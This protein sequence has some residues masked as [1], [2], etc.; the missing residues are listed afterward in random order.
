MRSIR[1]SIVAGKFVEFIY[2]F[3]DKMYPDKNFPKWAID[4]LKAV[5][6]DLLQRSQWYQLWKN[7]IIVPLKPIFI[8]LGNTLMVRMCPYEMT[9]IKVEAT[10]RFL[11]ICWWVYITN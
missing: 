3:M 10:S 5:Q 7:S 11:H 1:E 2:D 6:V 8:G 9:R 4:A